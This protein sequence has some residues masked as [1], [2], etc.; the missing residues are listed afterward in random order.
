MEEPELGAGRELQSWERKHKV[1]RRGAGGGDMS[2]DTCAGKEEL[3][4]GK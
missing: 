1:E 2:S 3:F 4:E